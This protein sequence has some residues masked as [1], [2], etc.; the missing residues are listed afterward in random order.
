MSDFLEDDVEIVNVDE[1][2]GEQKAPLV[3][4]EDVEEELL[5][6]LLGERE[7]VLNSRG[8]K[9]QAWKKWRRHLE[10]ETEHKVKNYPIKNASNV[11]PPLAQISAQ[12]MY[13]KALAFFDNKDPFWTVKAMSRDP[14]DV[15][16]AQ[17][18]TRYMSLLADSPTD[19][20]MA[21]VKKTVIMEATHMGTC[22]CKVPWSR[23]EWNFKVIDDGVEHT[24]TTVYHDGPEI[25]PI[26]VED[27]VYPEHWGDA[28]RMPWFSHELHLPVYEFKNYITRGIYET[29]EA[30]DRFIRDHS[31][32]LERARGANTHDASERTGV[33]DLSEFHFF[34]D[35]DNDGLA[36]DMIFTVH[37]ET[38]TIVRRAYNQ[39]GIR[40]IEPVKF[41]P[42]TFSVEGRGTGKITSH[43][44]DEAEAIRNLR[45]DSI[46]ASNIRMFA[47]KRSVINSNSEAMWPGKLWIMDEPDRDMRPLQLG[48]TYPSS[49]QA[50]NNA[51]SQAAQATGQ[52][53]VGR[54]FSDPRLGSRDTFRGQNMRLE[55]SEGI[56]STILSGMSHSFARIGQLVLFSLVRH[57]DQVLENE[58]ESM[59]ITEDEIVLLE[60]ILSM[61][62]AEIPR[63]LRFSV[64]TTDI[65]ESNE[66]RKQSLL[67]L[68]QIHTAYA[69][70]TMPLV[71]ALFGPE[72]QQ[73]QQSAPDLWKFMLEIYVGS[74][75]LMK[76]IY[77]FFRFENVDDYT[78]TIG[79]WERVLDML[80][81]MEN[82]LIGD[83]TGASAAPPMIDSP[84]PESRPIAMD[85]QDFQGGQ[86]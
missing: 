73:M 71:L 29:N 45:N 50:E 16:K 37:V 51:W 80:R 19:L 65:D 6:Y 79:K 39:T 24:K 55:Q 62:V 20:D 14:H 54:G 69:E 12:T 27:C 64:S 83:P 75:K 74:T 66:A 47:V 57:R 33:V 18:L 58:R 34:W 68:T 70:K 36:E 41:I 8:E 31:T 76:E 22:F 42:R 48:D 28:R 61:D 53:E 56:T 38:R 86:F 85:A 4:D 17:F 32:D 5:D 25:V 40:I 59:R 78:P 2:S 52:S 43:L 77:E 15:A 63:K 7:L 13:A 35:I 60:E 49:I 10:A 23:H 46:K 9:E 82:Q 67:M 1:I 11:S 72:G 30:V 3:F 44:Q 81:E 21:D 84:A 26:P